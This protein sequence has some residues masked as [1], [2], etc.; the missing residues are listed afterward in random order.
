MCRILEAYVDDA[1]LIWSIHRIPNVPFHRLS[2]V[3]AA[4]NL[5]VHDASE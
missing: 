2:T 1:W 5:S 4:L 3:L